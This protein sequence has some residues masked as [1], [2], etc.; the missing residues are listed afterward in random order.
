MRGR[1][2]AQP[3]RPS[4]PPLLVTGLA[5]WAATALLWPC[6]RGVPRGALVIGAAAALAGAA[7]VA[8]PSLVRRR[9][10]MGRTVLLGLLAALALSCLWAC[11]LQQQ[12][13]GNPHSD[14]WEVVLEE[15]ARRGEFGWRARARATDE[16]GR[17][18]PVRVNLPESMGLLQGDEFKAEASFKRPTEQAAEFYWNDGLA[19]SLT[20]SDREGAAL[21][22]RSALSALRQR[23]IETIAAHGDG[24]A[25]L[26]QALVCGYRAPIEDEGLYD[27]FKTVGLAHLVAV[28][29]AH[30]SIVVLFVGFGLRVLRAGRR[31]TT[32]AISLFLLGYMAFTGMPV[33][34]L[35]AALMAFSGLLSLCTDR[36]NSS[37]NAL[38]G[39]LVTFVGLDPPCAISASFVLSAGSTLG[40][41]LFAPLIAAAFGGAGSCARRLF[42]DAAALT[43][44]AALATQPYAAALFAQVPLLSLAANL[45]A[46]PLFTLACVVGFGAVLVACVLPGAAPHLMALAT[47]ASAP[48]SLVVENLAALPASCWPV[49]APVGLAVAISVV[50]CA[51]LWLWW[52]R[53]SGKRLAA[54]VAA[55]ALA[56]A[57]ARAPLG[58]A[59][60]AIVMLDVGQG[61][62]FLVRSQ[63]AA[64]LVDTGN[65]EAMLKTALARERVS[66]LDAV[67][68]THGDDDHCGAL[69]AL[70]DVA[71][72]DTLLVAEDLL[73]CPCASCGE[74]LSDAEGEGYPGG[75]AG[76]AL[77][78]TVR[79]GRFR[80]TVVWPGRFADE[81]GNA[82][83]LS[84][85]C[86]WD[87]DGDGEGEWTALLC[88]DAEAEQLVKMAERLPAEGVD[89]LKVGHHGSK[90]SLDASVADRV[91]P[92]VALIGVGEHNRYGHPSQEALDLLASIGCATY[93]SDEAGNVVVAFSEDTL[94]VSPERQE[95]ETR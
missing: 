57:I 66:R 5:L 30:L 18:V 61:D 2:C 46:A 93:C 86:S 63:G 62:S 9:S 94:T 17:T 15:D 25:G 6:L 70:G 38:G 20:V 67:A 72:V 90:K 79:C 43:M 49:D 44:A 77:G 54:A 36:R 34:V 23:A 52:P 85:L 71:A 39:C 92:S 7:L 35:R 48:L 22:G 58:G 26:L 45:I 41:V 47:L 53:I 81:G 84:F 12:T 10:A 95:C 75:V 40:I 65:Q 29:G 11:V 78:D 76:L 59:D 37:L 88:G 89:V 21:V 3:P 31:T 28:S 1:E 69:K 80:L 16:Q 32:L 56:L 83:S 87:G 82:D 68:I 33:S 14:T 91:S 24:R 55:V 74:L 60:D 64:L 19:G 51:A 50:A 13:D 27:Q 4:L 8:V 73:R 42:G